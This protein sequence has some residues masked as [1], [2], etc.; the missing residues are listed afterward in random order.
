M[1]DAENGQPLM[2]AYMNREALE[3]TI[4]EKYLPREVIY[5][6]KRGFSIPLDQFLKAFVPDLLSQ[7]IRSPRSFSSQYLDLRLLDQQIGRF[8]RGASYLSYRLWSVI[9]LEVWYRLHYVQDI[10]SETPFSDLV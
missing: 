5:R 9:C 7:V 3:Q 6:S 10:D 8:A 1:V 4:A 2:V